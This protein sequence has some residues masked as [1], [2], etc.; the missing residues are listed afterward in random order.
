MTDIT[1]LFSTRNGAAVLPRVLE[2][3]AR[4]KTDGF[5]WQ[6]VMVDNGSSDGSAAIANGFKGRI[7]I[8]VAQEPNPGKNRA[9]NAGLALVKGAFVI[10]TDDDAIPE[11]DFL[12]AWLEVSAR[13][14]GYNL[15]G[16]TI[17]PAFDAPPPVWMP[18][19]GAPYYALFAARDLK[20]GPIQSVDIFGP[21]MAVRRSVF[22]SGL[23]FNEE[24]GP[25]GADAQ[26]A[27]G[28][29][30]EFARRVEAAGNKAWFAAK[31]KVAHI[32]R[33]HQLTRAFYTGRAYRLGRGIACQFIEN[34]THPVREGRNAL[35]QLAGKAR[36]RFRRE[37]NRLKAIASK[38]AWAE[39]G[40]DYHWSRGFHDEIHRRERDHAQ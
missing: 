8:E 26:Y 40:W 4:Q 36:V 16:G 31:P 39:Y 19:S 18:M 20:E 29:E 33:A 13:A 12:A 34:G 37:W 22:D 14:K 5:S 35:R 3:Y 25:N 28:S 38:D 15:F 27:M 10:L 32:V 9:L 23:R 21:N 17:A 11:P 6:M 7:P 30:T 24:I 2:A 1:V